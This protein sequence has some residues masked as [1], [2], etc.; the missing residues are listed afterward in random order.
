MVNRKI[1]VN[2]LPVLTYRFL[3]MNEEQI[4]TGEL[5]TAETRIS[6]PEKLP[7]G[8]LLA[9]ELDAEGVQAFFAR[10][11]EK[12]K[13]STQEATPPNGDTSA[14]Y[15]TQALPSGMGREVEDLLVSCGV[16]AQVFR[17]PAGEK[18]KEPLVLKLH[19]QEAEEGKAC[20][21]RQVI[22]AEEGAEVS[23]ILDL[24]TGAEAEGAVGMQTLLLAKKDAVIHLYQVQMAG[25]KVQ[26]FDD[27]G[28]VAEENAKIDIVR[29]D[30]G[31]ERS[32]VGCHVNLLG[33]KSDLQVNTAYLCR[34]KQQYDM[35][36]IATHRGQ[37]STSDM[38][39][40]G[41]L[42][43]EAKKTFRGT[44]DFKKGSA[45]AAGEEAEDNLLLS[46]RT[47]NRTIPLILCEEEDVNGHHG[48]T[49]GQ[50]GED[51]MFYCQARGISEEEARRMMVRARMKSVARMIP[52]DHIRGY[53]EDY[54]RK[55]L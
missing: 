32:Y 20:L 27:I 23:V 54:L 10:T 15:E 6:L 1:G 7:E 21:L 29:M 40:R 50:L 44:L 48:A 49:I 37:K 46:D 2:N 5:E 24:H 33:K 17:V 43:D 25:E 9:E 52:D 47:V 31:G 55:T 39:F 12:I 3:R 4:E 30:L 16:K 36:Y 18:V 28:A 22:C 38:Q 11:R 41:I 45:G 8:I 19:R 42:M 35:D 13:E 14:R 51:L 53:V 26:T 34:K